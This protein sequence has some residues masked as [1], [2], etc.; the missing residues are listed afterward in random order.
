M[1]AAPALVTIRSNGWPVRRYRAGM[2]S[3]LAEEHVRLFVDL[4]GARDFAAVLAQGET[5]RSCVALAF[6]PECIAATSSA[7]PITFRRLLVSGWVRFLEERDGATSPP[8]PFF[9][10]SV[11]T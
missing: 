4:V 3:R 9:R 10:A 11:A 6:F 5:I 2:D 8:W 1:E 7:G